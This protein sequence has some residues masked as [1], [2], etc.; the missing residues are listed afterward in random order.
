MGRVARRNHWSMAHRAR[1]GTV[2]EGLSTTAG[3]CATWSQALLADAFGLRAFVA[4][5]TKGDHGMFAGV[6][7]PVVFP[8]ARGEVPIACYQLLREGDRVDPSRSREGG[9]C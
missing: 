3:P 7:G 9:D 4:P 5:H 6:S 2:A 1:G 8:H